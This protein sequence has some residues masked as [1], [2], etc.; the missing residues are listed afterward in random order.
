MTE[1][2]FIPPKLTMRVGIA[3]HLP[4]KLE[5]W[6]QATLLQN[7]KGALKFV[8]ETMDGAN[9]ENGR[10]SANETPYKQDGFNLR[11]MTTLA[12]GASQI[13]SKAAKEA[14][15]SI[16]AILPAKKEKYLEHLESDFRQD[17]EAW[18]EPDMLRSNLALDHELTTDKDE[19]FRRAGYLMIA[20]VDVL[21]VVWN[22]QERDKKTNRIAYEPAGSTTDIVAEAQR[23]GVEIIWIQHGTLHRYKDNNPPDNPE[24][25]FAWDP[26]ALDGQDN[27]AADDLRGNLL[28]ILAA[29]TTGLAL[30]GLQGFRKLKLRKRSCAFV[31]NFV[32]SALAWRRP[33]GRLEL[34]LAENRAAWSA[35]MALAKDIG[36]QKYA[37]RADSHHSGS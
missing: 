24:A 26:I 3:G 20:H 5:H 28:S 15:Y 35:S 27:T 4:E 32:V 34:R 30:E 7:I 22:G 21:I 8:T 25:D 2:A 37:A 9:A 31:Y 17:F 12:P 19:A 16:H 29:P 11:F 13:A 18:F 23:R 14:G 36:G 33:S 6:D 10:Y 1:S